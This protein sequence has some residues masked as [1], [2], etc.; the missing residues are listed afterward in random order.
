M[1]I[2]I[3]L[4]IIN[5]LIIVLN[6]SLSKF[7]NDFFRNLD[8][9]FQ[10]ISKGNLDIKINHELENRRDEIGSLSKSFHNLINNLKEITLNITQGAE[11]L[12]A[13]SQE[14]SVSAQQ[15][16]KGATQQAVSVEEI[17][18][19]MEEMMAN[20]EQNSSNA[21]ETEKISTGAAQ[22]IYS[23]KR[24]SQQSLNSI[25]QIATKITIIN[26]ISFQT[27]ILAL[28]AAVEAAR[29]GEHGKGF[30]VVASEVRKLAEKS[31]IAADEIVSLSN[32]SVSI[33]RESES[34]MNNIAPQIENTANLVKEISASSIE[35]AQGTNQ[36]NNAIQQLNNITQQNAAGSEE[37]AA[38]SEELALHADK[39]KSTIG[40]FKT[41]SSNNQ[42]IERKKKK[43]KHI[44]K[45]KNKKV[46]GFELNL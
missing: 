33:T 42:I 30:A 2:F 23:V 10:E 26:D 38:S 13:A 15:I 20:I 28:N 4:L 45:F 16:S 31:K 41:D 37:L 11:N 34:Q 18:A 1:N 35:Q 7:L 3:I 43:K 24:A 6:F 5:L 22:S 8:K 12:A 19:S 39:L 40:F 32:T 29:A 36:V 25:Q 46:N 14:I 9:D 27:N 17:S 44:I 21:A